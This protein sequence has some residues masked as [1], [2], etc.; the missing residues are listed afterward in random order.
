M[1]DP[2]TT[3]G[4]RR[5]GSP[6]LWVGVLALSMFV[7]GAAA[8]EMCRMCAAPFGR[9]SGPA[10]LTGLSLQELYNLDWPCLDCVD[11]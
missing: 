3:V 8:L 7:S 5:R 2:M 11:R 4:L 1:I 10:D 6:A 9:D